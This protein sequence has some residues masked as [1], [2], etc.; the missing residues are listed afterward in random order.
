MLITLSF[1]KFVFFAESKIL[2]GAA[3]KRKFDVITTAIAV[4]I[5]LL[6]NSLDWMTRS[7]RL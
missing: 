1:G 5:L 7:G 4:L 2:P 3:D 6:L